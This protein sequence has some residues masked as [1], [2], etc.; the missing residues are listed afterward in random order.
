[1]KLHHL[2]RYIFSRICSFSVVKTPSQ[3]PISQCHDWYPPEDLM[4]TLLEGKTMW[5]WWA[6]LSKTL[7]MLAQ[8]KQC[9][10]HDC[11]AESLAH[12]EQSGTPANAQ[13]SVIF[14][15]WWFCSPSWFREAEEGAVRPCAILFSVQQL[16]EVQHDVWGK[17]YLVLLWDSANVT[18][19]WM[20]GWGGHT[21]SHCV[22]TSAYWAMRVLPARKWA[23]TVPQFPDTFAFPKSFAKIQ[24]QKFH[25]WICD[26]RWYITWCEKNKSVLWFH[27][28]GLETLFSCLTMASLLSVH[29][30]EAFVVVGSTY[31]CEH[32]NDVCDEIHFGKIKLYW[33]TC[34]STK[35]CHF[36]RVKTWEIS[37]LSNFQCVTNAVNSSACCSGLHNLLLLSEMLYL[38]L[39]PPQ[40]HLYSTAMVSICL[41]LC[42]CLWG[43]F[44][45]QRSENLSIVSSSVSPL[46]PAFCHKWQGLFPA[47]G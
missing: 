46:A 30:V 17:S 28:E 22:S 29:Q 21:G 15:E 8:K 2:S 13:A 3:G 5:T 33:L 4:G 42:L 31:I 45:L 38:W 1:M 32:K 18:G 25:I 47:Q 34:L 36:F 6:W 23:A 19:E 37:S 10:G 39:T 44:V 12:K 27:I 41:C 11:L 14:W 20:V 40:Y 35:A 7:S 43:E 26:I 16:H 9:V 24:W